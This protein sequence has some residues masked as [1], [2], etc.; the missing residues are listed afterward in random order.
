MWG[1]RSHRLSAAAL[2]AGVSVLLT[3]CQT[4]PPEPTADGP[5]CAPEGGAS[6][7]VSV[8]G[9]LFQPPEVQFDTPLRPLTTERTVLVEGDGLEA[10]LG[11]L[12]TVEFVA[13]NGATG[14]PIEATGFGAPG[15]GRTVLTLEV[16]SAMPGVRRALVCSTPG[17]RVVGVVHPGDGLAEAGE[18]LG[19]GPDDPLV[20]VFDVL[21]VAADRAEGEAQPQDPALPSVDD[22]DGFPVVSV[23]VTPP[24]PGLVAVPV[25]LGSGLE[26]RAGSDVTIRYRSVLWRNGLT[27]DENWSDPRPERFAMADLLP[28]V[29]EGLVGKTVGSRVLIVVPPQLG[30]GPG[31]DLTSSVTGTDTLVLAIDILATT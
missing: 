28:G 22:A 9:D 10:G 7:A 24:P 14:D 5:V 25:I 21:A 13:F 11:S 31:G 20:Y 18:V 8:E 15:L 27:V 23:P 2:I 6:R 29:A 30:F 1:R 12:V 3:G 17:S 26:V 4:P 19:L 16:E